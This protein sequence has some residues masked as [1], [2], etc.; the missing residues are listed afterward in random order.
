MNKTMS[1]AMLSPLLSF[2]AADKLKNWAGNVVYG[3]ERWYSVA[4]IEQTAGKN[5]LS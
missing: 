1:T 2:A 3:S 5:H 4:S